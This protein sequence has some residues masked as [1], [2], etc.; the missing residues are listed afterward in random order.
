MVEETLDAWC[1]L[2]TSRRSEVKE[3]S[4]VQT[5][6]LIVTVDGKFEAI[7]RALFGTKGGLSEAVIQLHVA[8]DG[9][10]GTEG[11]IMHRSV[12]RKWNIS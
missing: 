4:D 12:K 11:D 6:D 7:A 1:D 2:Q 5:I 3:D 10:G 8:G 9:Q